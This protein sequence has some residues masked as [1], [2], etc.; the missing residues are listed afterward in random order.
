MIFFLIFLLICQIKLK[1]YI[2]WLLRK[3]LSQR[4]KVCFIIFKLIFYYYSF[5]ILIVRQN[6]FSFGLY[7]GI[8]LLLIVYYFHTRPKLCFKIIFLFKIFFDWIFWFWELFIFS[9]MWKFSLSSKSIWNPNIMQ[10]FFLI[11]LTPWIMLQNY[12]F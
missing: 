7:V 11:F 12:Y 2:T 4:L 6:K 5:I 9:F 10:C 1:F 8:N 3:F